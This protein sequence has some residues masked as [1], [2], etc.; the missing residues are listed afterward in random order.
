MSLFKLKQI[1]SLLFFSISYMLLLEINF[2][3]FKLFK[4]F[5]IL[6]INK[7]SPSIEKFV[8]FNFSFFKLIFFL[9]PKLL[10]LFK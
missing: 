6:S 3:E 2:N 1:F 8:V 9:P 10:K 5:E 7:L 4:F